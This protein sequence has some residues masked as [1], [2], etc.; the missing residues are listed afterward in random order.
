MRDEQHY[1]HWALAMAV[2]LFTASG[3]LLAFLALA[4]AI[5]GDLRATFGWLAAALVVDGVDGPMARAVGVDRH[6]PRWDGAV[7]DLV[8]DF[9]TYVLTP[10]VAIWRSGLLRSEERRVGTEC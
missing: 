6:A 3:A 4:A 9:L 5:E 8:I 1:R 10:L 7:L 2:H